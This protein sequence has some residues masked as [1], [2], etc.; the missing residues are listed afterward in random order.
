VAAQRNA[1]NAE[2][3]TITGRAKQ[4]EL[5]VAQADDLLRAAAQARQDVFTEAVMARGASPLS[6][7]VWTVAVP[8]L[9]TALS[10]SPHRSSAGAPPAPRAC[11]RASARATWGSRWRR[12]CWRSRWAGRSGAGC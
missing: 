1:L 6:P 10:R 11:P 9:G 2:L 7:K 3:A 5:T 12:C 4:A 8:E